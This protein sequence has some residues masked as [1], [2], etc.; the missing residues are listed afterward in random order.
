MEQRCLRSSF[1]RLAVAME[2]FHQTVA[3]GAF[4]RPSRLHFTQHGKLVDYAALHLIRR[5]VGEGH[6]ED[7]AVDGA[8]TFTQGVAPA[9]ILVAEEEL[10]VIVGQSESLA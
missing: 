1:K 5:L 9:F 3:I 10:Y 6:G 8:R 2:F 7:R 4:P